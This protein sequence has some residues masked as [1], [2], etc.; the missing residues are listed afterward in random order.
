[1]AVTKIW[2][3]R[4]RL[5][6]V[7]RYAE[8][9]EK[10]RTPDLT[11]LKNDLEETLNYAANDA[12]TIRD[13]QLF[14]SGVNCVPAI[15]RQQME[16]TKQQFGKTGG[17]VAFH[18]Y[19]SFPPG[20]VTPE[21]CHAIGVELA[22]H[23]W[24]DRF[25]VLVATH[26]NTDCCHNHFVL[27]SVS[28][29]DGKRYNDCKATYRALQQA[30]NRLCREHGLSVVEPSGTHTPRNIY[31]AEKQGEP[32]RYNIMRTDIDQA[33]F[34]CRTFGDLPDALRQMGYE[35]RFDPHRTYAT[36]KL[37]GDKRAVRFK[38]LG[39]DYAE[40]SLRRRIAEIRRLSYGERFAAQQELFAEPGYARRTRIKP[41][42]DLLEILAESSGLYRYY[43]YY[44]YLFHHNYAQGGKNHPPHPA[45][46]E[47]YRRWEQLEQEMQLMEQY[48]LDTAE[49]VEKFAAEKQTEMEQLIARREKCRNRLRRCS[50]P[51]EADRLHTDKT[52]LTTKITAIRRELRIVRRILPR[53]K[54]MREKIE[55]MTGIEQQDR[56]DGGYER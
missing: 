11:G 45:M 22:K 43:R 40:D 39:E 4:G 21:Q 32:T 46:W 30:S 9:E 41:P 55:W 15:A 1:M 54:A 20:E 38:T 5:D 48:S 44:R 17:T 31:Q 13:D 3:V 51:V 18:A 26:L 49:E 53:V 6:S 14:V 27:N 37:P 25:Q 35:V 28:F 23:L 47:E 10:T 7:I 12:K 19:Q 2:P 34:H 52:D 8:N 42:K 50:N 24:G 36:L 33:L 56:A 16:L 29:V